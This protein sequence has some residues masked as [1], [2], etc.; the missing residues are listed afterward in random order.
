MAITSGFFNSKSGDRKYNAEQMSK[1]FD[2]LI[3]SGVFP[4][5]STQLQVVESSGMTINVLPGRGIVDCRWV[6]NDANHSLV[7]ESS[8]ALLDRIDAI[9]MKLDLTEEVRAINIEVKK[10]TP[11][12][13]PVPPSMTRDECVQEY[14]LATIRVKRLAEV[15]TQAD[16]TDTRPDS[17]V[18]GW[19]TGLITQV[20]T[21]T[22]FEQWQSAYEQ[23]YE[24]SNE[25]FAQWF[26]SMK[27]TA[28]TAAPLKLYST[29][30]VATV[31][32][33]QTIPIEIEKYAA[34]LDILNV[35]INGMKLIEGEDYT[36]DDLGKTV[37]LTKSVDKNTSISFEVLKNEKTTEAEVTRQV[38]TSS[39]SGAVVKGN[40]IPQ[41]AWKKSVN[42]YYEA[43]VGNQNITSGSV[44][45]FNMAI[46]SAEEEK[47]CGILGS[48]TTAEGFFI[49]YA[50]EQPQKDIY[51]DYV[52]FKNK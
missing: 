52:V 5:P 28:A 18:C 4:N 12:T 11:G 19:V 32:D 27:D 45:V 26:E 10:G 16:I 44:I 25:K 22:L 29:L 1:Y 24:E 40:I 43:K 14:C 8:D 36:I 30:Y 46:E 35:F 9:I 47:R 41:S 38:K 37:T 34:D 17:K 23:F 2:K 42:G 33:Q 15:I 31:Q 3:T 13:N 20:D 21:S 39:I 51:C 48:A 50:K 6:D 49:V 7:I